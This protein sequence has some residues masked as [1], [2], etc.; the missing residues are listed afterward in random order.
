MNFSPEDYRTIKE[1]ALQIFMDKNLPKE[2]P[3]NFMAIC[4]TQAVL[5]FLNSRGYKV[6]KNEVDSR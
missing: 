4:Y 3:D 6:E 2:R 1:F 5:H